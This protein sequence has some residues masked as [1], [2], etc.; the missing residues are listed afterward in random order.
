MTRNTKLSGKDKEG[1]FNNQI[2]GRKTQK[3]ML[4]TEINCHIS[5]TYFSN[6][7]RQ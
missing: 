7:Q 2:R 3:K 4:H 6:M 1:W 5:L